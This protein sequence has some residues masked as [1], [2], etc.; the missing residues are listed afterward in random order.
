MP[1][2]VSCPPESQRK[3]QK[4]RLGLELAFVR[5]AGPVSDWSRRLGWEPTRVRPAGSVGSWSRRGARVP[6]PGESGGFALCAGWVQPARGLDA[7]SRSLGDSRWLRTRLLAR[8]LVPRAGYLPALGRSVL[9]WPG[10]EP[11]PSN[12]TCAGGP[13]GE[14]PPAGGLGAWPPESTD[15]ESPAKPRQRRAGDANEEAPR[16]SRGEVTTRGPE[17]SRR[18]GGPAG[19]ALNAPEVEHTR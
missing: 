9:L 10:T 1:R 5:P 7:Y 4:R 3:E 17:P 18:L 14:A 13:G 19:G 2:G 6:R 8:F 12:P 11:H 16:S 15:D